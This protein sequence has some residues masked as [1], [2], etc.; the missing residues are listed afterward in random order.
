M[1]FTYDMRIHSEIKPNLFPLLP[2]R[3]AWD[4]FSFNFRAVYMDGL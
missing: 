3:K 1:F 2:V 4:P